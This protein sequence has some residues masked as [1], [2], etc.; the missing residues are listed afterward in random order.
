M[1][2]QIM[3]SILILMLGAVLFIG[4][5]CETAVP[6]APDPATGGDDAANG[7]GDGGDSG[8]TAPPFTIVKTSIDV[9]HDAGLSAGNDLIAFGTSA[10]TGVSYVFPSTH[11]TAATPVTNSTTYDSSDFAVGN[12]TIFLVGGA[13]SGMPFRVSVYNVD[14][15]TI[16]QTFTNSQVRLARIPVSQHDVGNIQADGDYCVVVCDQTVVT[17]GKILKVVDVSGATPALISFT[18]NPASSG[19]QVQQVAIDAATRTVVAVANDTFYVYDITHPATA[20]RQIAS[21]NGVG[22]IQMKMSGAYI[23]AVDDQSTPEAILV[24][25]TTNT[26]RELTDAQATFDVA[27]G[28]NTFGFFADFDAADSVG[29]DQRAAVGVVPGPGF[30]KTALDNRI[31]GATTNNGTVG[32]GG[33]MTIT[34]NGGYVFLADSYFQYSPGNAS[35][36]VPHDPNGEDPYACPAWDIDS[37]A[38]TVGFKTAATRGDST[39]TKLGYIVLN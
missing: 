16:T 12:R 1:Y 29:G 26:I 13:A 31:D 5:A 20:P 23:V 4:T 28:S 25:L 34:P 7:D 39:N 27:I 9:R 6:A 11:P 14:T 33:T 35:F 15:A 2:S 18:T 24:D 22:D 32:F 21:P 19:M 8:T 3:K 30:T 17:G 10:T 36:S 38:N 37:S